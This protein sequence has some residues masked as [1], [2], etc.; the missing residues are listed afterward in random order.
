MSLVSGSRSDNRPDQA[1]LRAVI[2]DYG[3]VITNPLAETMA[4]FCT[5]MGLEPAMLAQ[6]LAR[7]GQEW[8]EAPMARL[9][10][11]RCAEAELVAAVLGHLPQLAAG[12]AGRSFGEHWFAGRHSEPA[13]L[14]LIAELR[15]SGLRTALLTNNVREWG[16]RWRAQLDEALFDVIVDSSAE[17]VRKPEPEI[18]RRMLE[19]LG[20]PARQCLFVDDVAE[21]RDSAAALGLRVFAWADRTSVAG[22]RAVIEAARSDEPVSGAASRS[23]A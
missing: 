13:V 22:L 5:R 23:A 4:S 17:G 3:G 1:P 7:V 10:K 6:T 20:V 15:A 2:F 11:G 18:Y 21:N 19:R 16:P 9:E 14:D 8:G 12:L